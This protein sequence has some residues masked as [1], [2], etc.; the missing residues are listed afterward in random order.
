MANVPCAVGGCREVS[1]K[2]Q[3]GH[4]LWWV[5]EGQ[6][7]ESPVKEL[8]QS[9]SPVLV[10]RLWTPS[11]HP[12]LCSSPHTGVALLELLLQLP[13]LALLPPP[14]LFSQLLLHS[15]LPLCVLV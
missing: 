6:V 15:S 13:P 4:E 11:N 7:T 9:V 10:S 8:V 1:R 5:D 2:G 12:A 3:A 14:Y